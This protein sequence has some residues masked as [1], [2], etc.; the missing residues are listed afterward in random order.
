VLPANA[1]LTVMIANTSKTT[2]ETVHRM[3]EGAMSLTFCKP[4]PCSSEFRNLPPVAGYSVKVAREFFPRPDSISTLLRSCTHMPIAGIR[5]LRD[6]TAG[7]LRGQHGRA[8]SLWQGQPKLKPLE[9]DCQFFQRNCL[10]TYRNNTPYP[11]FN[12]L[13]WIR[14][15]I[16]LSK[17]ETRRTEPG[18][19]RLRRKYCNPGPA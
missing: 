5:P 4:A 14:E 16:P 1:A 9:R 7:Q 12:S 10:A 6:C 19:L 11:G 2:A 17:A 18:R 3:G 15:P 13:G 8:H